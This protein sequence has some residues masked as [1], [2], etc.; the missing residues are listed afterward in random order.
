M[1]FADARPDFAQW[2]SSFRME[3]SVSAGMGHIQTFIHPQVIIT[4]HESR[5]DAFFTKAVRTKALG[6]GKSVIELPLAAAENL[7]WITR[8]DSGSLAGEGKQKYVYTSQLL[9]GRTSLAYDLRRPA[10]SCSTKVF[11]HSY[12]TAKEYRERRLF[13]SSTTT[14]DNRIAS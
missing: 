9:T 14:S 13:W 6:I 8:L 5:E 2:S 11:G 10:H 12:K 3:V 1:T 7:M 4:D